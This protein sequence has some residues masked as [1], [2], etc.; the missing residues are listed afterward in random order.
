MRVRNLTL[1]CFLDADKR[2]GLL[3]TSNRQTFFVFSK[4]P[5]S[6]PT[7][8]LKQ[9]VPELLTRGTQFLTPQMT[10]NAF[11]RTTRPSFYALVQK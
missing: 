6:H 9:K 7:I 2:G 1:F 10:S 4:T 8:G 5:L 3:D 11:V